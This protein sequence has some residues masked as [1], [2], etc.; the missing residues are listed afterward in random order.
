MF[1]LPDTFSESNEDY[2]VVNAVKKF[3]KCRPDINC[4]LGETRQVLLSAV[5]KYANSSEKAEEDTLQWVDSV[6]K[7]G[8]KDLYVKELSD[9]SIKYIQNVDNIYKV[10]QPILEENK[11]NHF[12][13]NIY[14][15][16]M[17]LVR[18]QVEEKECLIYTFYLCQCV[19]VYD[20]KGDAKVR[21]Y[22]ICV[23]VYPESGLIVGRGKPRQNMF[24]YDKK[25]INLDNLERVS[26]EL[27]IQKGMQYILDI[28]NISCKDVGEVN[29]KFKN[30]LYKLLEKYTDTPTE[31]DTLIK[32]NIDKIKNVI[33][34]IADDVCI[35]SNKQD[36]ESDIFNLI[37]KYFSINYENK[38]IFTKGREAY[39]LRISATDEEESKV[40]QKSA[41]EH[42][43]QSKAIFFDNKKMMQKSK[44]C[45][46]IVFKFRRKNKTYFDEEFKVKIGVKSNYCHVKFFEYTEEVDIQNVLQLFINS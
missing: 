13:N 36:I 31:I 23:D 33:N 25:G 34:V 19:F 5:V 3:I 45:D 41:Q 35:G 32:D 46:G 38:E 15:D 6:V 20:G 21:W 10:I 18:F 29:W 28:L 2:I 24:K 42:P 26:P 22:P 4:K 8:I 37:E 27:R 12:C 39:P 16:S 44:I 9:E 11:E 1:V 30:C 40:D 14:T 17:K 43:L 7:E